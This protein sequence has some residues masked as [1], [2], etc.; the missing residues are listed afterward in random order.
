M[1]VTLVGTKTVGQVCLSIALALPALSGSLSDLLA[2]IANLEAQVTANV[3]L[4]ATPPDPTALAAAIA[5]AATA[6]VSQIAAIL[7][8]IPGPLLEANASLSADVVALLSLKGLLETVVA[9]FTTAGSVGGVHVWSI[10]STAADVPAELSA[11]LTTIPG[12]PPATARV[13]GVV[14]L[15][16]SPAAFAALSSVLL[17]G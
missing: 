6:A 12:S 14:L 1:S 11:A 9:T 16:D 3:A 17:T 4:I 2:R 5:A 15:A 7:A 8:S 10:D 13:Q